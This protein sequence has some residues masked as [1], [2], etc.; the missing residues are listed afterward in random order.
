MREPH[1]AAAVVAAMVKAV[2]IPVTVKVRKGWDDDDNCTRRRQA[3]RGR[4]R[5]SGDDPRQDRKAVM[6]R[7]R[8]WEFVRHVAEQLTVPVFGSG[9]CIEPEQIVER[10]QR[11]VKGVFVGLRCRNPWILTQ[12][13]DLLDG[14]GPRA[15]TLEL[16]GRSAR[17]YRA[18]ATGA[19]SG[20]RWLP[21]SGARRCRDRTG[22]SWHP[23]ARSLGDQ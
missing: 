9:D 21:A 18:V 5:G 17:L 23:S 14:R 1:H 22:L 8:S 19:C 16:R 20:R 7:H 3:R 11:G 10:L 15:V 12:A 2:K 4:W 6:R 13:Q